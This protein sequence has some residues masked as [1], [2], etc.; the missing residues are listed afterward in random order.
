[1]NNLKHRRLWEQLRHSL[2]LCIHLRALCLALAALAVGAAIAAPASAEE[3]APA[4]IGNATAS[5]PEPW[6]RALEALAVATS[7][8]GQP[9]SCPDARVTL[10]LP[11]DPRDHALLRGPALLQVEDGAG[12]RRCPVASPADVVPVG[13]AMMAR[14]F[15]IELPEPPPGANPQPALPV[16]RGGD[17]PPSIM[18]PLE[19]RSPRSAQILVDA[20]AGSRFTGPTYA[21]LMGAELR[22]ALVLNRWSVGLMARYDTAVAMLQQVPDQ[23]ALS[24]VSIG[25][26]AGFRFLSAP[27]ELTV[28]VE[29][30]LAVVLMGALKPGDTEPD[31]DAHVDMRLGARLGAA[32][33]FS[34]RLRMLC[35]LGA[36]GAPAG[37]FS[38]R[39]SRRKLLPGLPGYMV[40]LS[41]GVEMAVLP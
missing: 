20:L 6:R 36:E 5:L 19:R 7:R 3:C 11:R 25:L 8:E 38:D 24:S 17:A 28:A 40:G 23:F 22:T 10:L 12:V 39:Q 4:Q 1:M 14:A 30:S 33:P 29:P 34:D 21:V 9:W 18:P 16:A 35:A 37:L 13:E 2:V 26:P 27:V 15:T 32:I 41:V 31:I